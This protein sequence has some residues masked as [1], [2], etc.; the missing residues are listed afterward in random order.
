MVK[1]EIFVEIC[2]VE[3][4]GMTMRLVDVEILL[5]I[6]EELFE[7]DA[8]LCLKSIGFSGEIETKPSNLLSSSPS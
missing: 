1:F 3:A 8:H 5:L 2:A 4:S 7:I 6:A